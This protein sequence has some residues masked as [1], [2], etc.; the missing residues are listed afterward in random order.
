[1]MFI[2]RFL[3]CAVLSSKAASAISKTLASPSENEGPEENLRQLRG[4]RNAGKKSVTTLEDGIRKLENV[5]RSLSFG[6][7]KDLDEA[8]HIIIACKEGEGE[9][10]C[11]KRISSTIPTEAHDDFRVI[12]YMEL[13]NAYSCEVRGDLSILDALS[14]YVHDDP[15]RETMHIKESVRIHR[16]LQFGQ[17]TPYG[18]ELVKA[19]DVW[20]KYNKGENVRVCVMDT[21]V[22]RDH[23]DLDNDRF[24]G[25]DGDELVQPWYR[26]TDG[27]G[28]HVAGTIAASDNNEGV[29]GVAPEAEIFIARVF[30]SNGQFYSSN[31]ITALQACKDGGADV[32][33]MSLGGFYSVDYEMRAYADLHEKFGIVTVAASGNTGGDDLMYPAAYDNVI[34]VG[35]VNWNS[36]RSSFSTKNNKLDVAAPGSSIVSSR[37]RSQIH[38]S[39]P[40]EKSVY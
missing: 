6:A 25:Y 24:F 38:Q 40:F 30:S 15:R 27:H 9:F 8:K 13:V 20:K 12:N 29:V 17:S 19:K 35:S 34:S 39:E 5:A 23:P 16:N 7:E 10:M 3:I 2:N 1:M 22:D 4:G 26:D 28:T 11:K 33:S 21:G 32:I 18:I 14:D 37:F 36:D 31:I